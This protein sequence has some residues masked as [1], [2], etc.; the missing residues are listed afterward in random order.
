MKE[1][2][3]AITELCKDFLFTLVRPNYW[4]MNHRYN[5][6]W[7]RAILRGLDNPVFSEDDQ[8]TVMF[9]GKCIWV[10]NYLDRS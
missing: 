2:V 3:L 6:D 4:I 9:H 5:R 10:E 1:L 8:Y 7:D